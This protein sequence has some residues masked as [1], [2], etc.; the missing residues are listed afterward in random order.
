MVVWDIRVNLSNGCLWEIFELIYLIQ[1]SY[2]VKWESN[3]AVR[4]TLNGI[5]FWNTGAKIVIIS[6]ADRLSMREL[7][8]MTLCMFL[9]K[10]CFFSRDLLRRK[11]LSARS[12]YSVTDF[13]RCHSKI[14]ASQSLKRDMSNKC[15][16][17]INISLPVI[18]AHKRTVS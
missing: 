12:A 15:L 13:E 9:R 5:I 16:R 14:N 10:R 6:E 1:S 3:A 4:S 11:S 18:A 17:E 7:Q 2:S 8:H